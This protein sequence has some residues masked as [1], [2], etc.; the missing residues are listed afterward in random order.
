MKNMLGIK[1]LLVVALVV[2][3]AVAIA[4]AAARASAARPSD[5][6]D[7]AHARRSAFDRPKLRNGLL[8][9]DGTDG[10]DAI[11]L[12]L[13][14]G[15]THVIEVDF[16]GSRDFNFRRD[17]V[18]TI[19]VDAGAG[20]DV[21]RVDDSNGAFTDTIPTTLDGGDGNDTLSGGAGA[22]TLL[23]GAGNDSIDGNRGNDAARMGAGDDTFVW[24]PGDGSDTIEGE[25]GTDT[26]L[27][28]GAN[29]DEQ[30][31]LSANGNRLKFVRDPGNITMDTAGVERVDFD[32]LGGSD[33]VTVND[34]TGTGV[35]DV[36]LDLGAAPD[37]AGDGQ[38]DSITVNGTDR[39]D[40]VTVAGSN[41]SLSVTGLAAAVNISGTDPAADTLGINALGG[42]DTVDASHLA[43]STLRLGVDGG[44]GNDLIA[45]GAGADVL[46]GGNGKDSI[47][48]NG[49]DDIGILGSGDDTFVWDPGDGSDSVEGQDGV[50]TMLFNGANIAEKVDLSANG[51]RLRFFRDV[52]N[53][54]MDT[55]GVETVDFNAGGGA[56]TV[57]VNDLTETDVT[58]VNTN[59][60][61]IGGRGGDGS[62]DH[63]IV[64]GTDGPERIAV[65][66]G[67]G[68][69]RV[70]GLAA[71]VQVT[72]AEPANDTLTV[73]GL[74][75]ADTIAAAG[76]AD[77]SVKLE[78]NGGDD[79]DLLIGSDGS[80]LANGG[81]G[82]DA[83]SLGAGDDTFVWNPGD[84]SDSIEGQDGVDTMLFNGAGVAEQV[85]LSANGPR[86]RFFR[87]IANVTMDTVGVEQVDFN[88][89][90]G[91]DTITVG[92]L[93]GTDVT[94][95]NLDLGLTAG[96]PG[97][98]AADN[99]F[100]EGTDGDDSIAV[101]GKNGSARVTGLA[102][103]VNIAGAEPANDTLEIDSR[104]GND[105]IDASGLEAS[106][107]QLIEN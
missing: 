93:T 48:G 89:L 90:G 26:M 104:G 33:A 16:G 82:A 15:D 56:D 53:I 3:A 25:D 49:G 1:G 79:A 63:V 99:V 45:G 74:A 7:A 96:G 44:E 58:S 105:A 17:R 39:K 67:D 62:A 77:S 41:G 59:L 20:D 22:E 6:Q 91:P 98:G 107:I 95:V 64:N 100:V 9:I 46:R 38:P 10:D 106:A 65:D 83:A 80:D 2:A 12:R 102:A 75:G 72:N 60:Q 31:T 57:T 87:D 97:D 37:I 51:R 18:A 43:A 54:T 86:L 27:F 61:P 23:G 4:I 32:A 35:T 8:Q 92:D 78:L 81:K 29:L 88:A 76:M 24:D 101:E 94:D 36:N 47:D 55:N 69:A 14:A 66:G 30:V 70:T 34:L 71:A 5:Q 85:T 73:N 103:T 84:G 21:V 19:A 68:S 42:D 52:G 28:V 40:A 11:T 13:K 50:D